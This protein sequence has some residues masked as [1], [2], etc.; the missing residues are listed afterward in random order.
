M[1]SGGGSS[2]SSSSSGYGNGRTNSRINS[3]TI[4][5]NNV[6]YHSHVVEILI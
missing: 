1:R 4:L 2:S 6:L 3:S 5:L